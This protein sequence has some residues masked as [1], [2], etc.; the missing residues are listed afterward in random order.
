MVC[1]VILLVVKFNK[2]VKHGF[3]GGGGGEVGDCV[4]C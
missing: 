1:V 4:P 3:G 2:F